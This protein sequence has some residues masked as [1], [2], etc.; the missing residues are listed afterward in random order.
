MEHR[1]QVSKAE[2]ERARELDLLTYLQT[3]EPH[4]LVRISSAV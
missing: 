3:Y 1:R 2:I 4:E